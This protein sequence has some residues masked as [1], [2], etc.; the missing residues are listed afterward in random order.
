[1]VQTDLCL[2]TFIIISCT[3]GLV[4]SWFPDQWLKP[5]P[6][7]KAPRSNHWTAREFLSNFSFIPPISVLLNCTLGEFLHLIFQLCYSPFSN[8]CFVISPLNFYLEK[9]ILKF[10]KSLVDFLKYMKYPFTFLVNLLIAVNVKSCSLV[11]VNSAYLICIWLLQVL[12]A[13]LRIID[14]CCSMK[15]L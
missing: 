15:D 2:L 1:M 3:M 14:L 9:W 6:G 4:G 5:G 11:F 10:P 12:V 8:I 7:K 13:S